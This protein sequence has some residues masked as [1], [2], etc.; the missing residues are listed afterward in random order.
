M[1]QKT[2][3]TKRQDLQK[4]QVAQSNPLPPSIGIYKIKGFLGKGGMGSVYKGWDDSLHR[5]VAIKTLAVEFGGEAEYRNR[6]L[7][8]ARALAKLVHPNITQIYSAGEENNRLYFA[9]EFV[10]G[11]T[12]QNLLDSQGK[13]SV[14]DALKIVLEICQGLRHAHQAG[15]IHRDIKPANILIGNDGVAK[16]TDFGIAKLT[17]DDQKLTK[18]GVMVGTPTY[19]SPEQARG[20]KTDF[21]SDIYSLGVTLYEFVMGEP[22]FVADSTMTVLMKHLN[23]PVRFP[24]L[25]DNLPLPPPMT[26]VI[27]KMMAKKPDSR[28]LS[29]DHL[30]EALSTL[31]GKIEP[32]QANAL[33]AN[34]TDDPKLTKVQPVSATLISASTVNN[35]GKGMPAFLKLGAA[36]GVLIA[37]Y[38][39]FQQWSDSPATPSPTTKVTHNSNISP[40]LRPSPARQLNAAPP[41]ES[42]P[43]ELSIDPTA[44]QSM[45]EKIDDTTYRIFGT[46]RNLRAEPIQ[47]LMVEVA[48]IDEFDEVLSRLEAPAEPSLILSGESTRF[49]IL[50]K[51]VENFKQHEITLLE[52]APKRTNQQSRAN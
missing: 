28:Y 7:V 51:N 50:F 2:Q 37:T 12:T 22:P 44:I 33:G 23:E 39:I 31:Q 45:V 25:K 40:P 4:T 46:I 30:I 11:P 15:V 24:V 32:A 17:L 34:Q 41:I 36:M 49:S 6:F 14:N 20:D 13:F 19:I 48:L 1:P 16:I 35:K 9:M 43:I 38:F 10:D 27:R 29:Y 47:K 26:G 21:R 42:Q 52:T 5:F 3:I 18:T 8:E